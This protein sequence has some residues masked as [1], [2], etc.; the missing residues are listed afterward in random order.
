VDRLLVEWSVLPGQALSWVAMVVVVAFSSCLDVAAIEMEMGT[1][2]D[3]DHELQ[4]VGL[5]N[6]LSGSL[7]GYTGSY[8]FSQTIFNLRAK[9]Q[10]R[11]TGYVVVAAELGVFLLPCSPM[12]YLPTC[13]FGC[14]L[15]LIATDL[16]FEWLVGAKGKMA[17]PEYLVNVFT[18]VCCVVYG[19]EAGIALGVG[20]AMAAFIVT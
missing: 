13:F 11:V 2:L 5:S 9:V 3:Y 1:P 20:C 14:L 7:G 17:G 4:T 6:V 16:C 15:V 8:I 19:V 12:A 18:F 10:S